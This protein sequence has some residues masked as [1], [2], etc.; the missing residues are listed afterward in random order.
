M[1]GMRDV[2]A[3]AGV[4]LSTVSAVF[5]NDK[6]VSDEIRDKVLIAAET[7]GYKLPPKK[8]RPKHLVGVITPSIASSFYSKVLSGIED[9]ML[10][11]GY[12]ILF[13]DSQYNFQRERQFI[14]MLRKK[15]QQLAGVIICSCCPLEGEA[16]YYQ[17]LKELFLN[18]EIPVT[19]IERSNTPEGFG[20][21]YQEHF[22]N[23]YVATSYLIERNHQHIAHI[24]TLP[25]YPTSMEKMMGY[26][27]AL[28]DHGLPIEE[29]LICAGDYTPSSGY[30]AM[31]ELMTRTGKMTAVLAANDQM[32]VGCM[33]AILSEGKRIPEDIAVVGID[34][35]SIASLVTPALTTINVPT[36]QMGWIA[37][38]IVLGR[39]YST[40]EKVKVDSNLVIRKSTDPY[41]SGEWE[42]FGW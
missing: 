29:E 25:K 15:Y 19:V 37:S 32:A 21:V 23:A 40:N 39:D 9:A 16:E 4:S 8:S 11:A 35:I 42:L 26:R 14:H 17:E 20:A 28:E 10:E 31:K 41:A 13:F 30:M 38:K 3:M 1:P 27:K 24:T 18:R 7:I 2:A 36:Y 5:S 12:L 34:N 22:Q 6:Y 33:K